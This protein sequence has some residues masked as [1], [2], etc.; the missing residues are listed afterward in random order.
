MKS[1]IEQALAKVVSNIK[2]QHEAAEERR[3]AGVTVEVYPPKS[4]VVE[5][6]RP[7]PP[8]PSRTGG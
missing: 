6:G 8:P 2:A 1:P 7:A 5:Y 4:E 3:K